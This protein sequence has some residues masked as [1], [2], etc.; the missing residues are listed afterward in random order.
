MRLAVLLALAIFLEAG[1]WTPLEVTAT[2]YCP[3]RICCGV[4]AAGITAD[5]TKV[6][7]VPYGVASDPNSLPYGT[8]VWIPAGVGYLD[9]SHAEDEARQFRV[10]DTGGIVRR[11]TRETGRVHIDLRF[12]QH[13]NARHFGVKRI[14]IY[15]WKE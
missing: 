6:S 14:T 15:V 7:E 9:H 13:R 11:R 5:N 4:R 1:E 2:A 10:D 12:I 3:C 8:T